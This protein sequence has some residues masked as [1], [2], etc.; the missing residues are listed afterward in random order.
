MFQLFDF[1]EVRPVRGERV[2]ELDELA[3]D[4]HRVVGCVL[5]E[6]KELLVLRDQRDAC[7]GA[8]LRS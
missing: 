2:E 7:H 6:P 5:E 4:D 3:R 1:A 8:P